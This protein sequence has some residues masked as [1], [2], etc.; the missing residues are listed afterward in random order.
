MTANT[1]TEM[2]ACVAYSG[3][4]ATARWG[5]T[6]NSSETAGKTMVPITAIGTRNVSMRT[7]FACSVVRRSVDGGLPASGR[8]IAGAA[9]GKLVMRRPSGGRLPG[10][11]A[12]RVPR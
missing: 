12:V 11:C 1:H 7:Y 8:R 10:R 6:K 2:T 9:V 5:T 4:S 3:W